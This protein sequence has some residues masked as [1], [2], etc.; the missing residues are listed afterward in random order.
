MHTHDVSKK[1]KKKKK[2]G[3]VGGGDIFSHRLP[4]ASNRCLNQAFSYFFT[5]SFL[6]MRHGTRIK[7]EQINGMRPRFTCIKCAFCTLN[8]D[9]GVGFV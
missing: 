6:S 7:D 3:G 9:N 4:L 5:G 2:E 1:K 8:E